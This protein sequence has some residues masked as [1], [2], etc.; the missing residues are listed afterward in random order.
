MS[1]KEAGGKLFHKPAQIGQSMVETA[2]IA[3]ILILMLIGVFEVGWALRGY[4]IILN[5]TREA[6]RFAARGYVDFSDGSGYEV[7]LDHTLDTLG[8]NLANP[9]AL[10]EGDANVGMILTPTANANGSII[11][12][13]FLINTQQPLTPLSVITS[14]DP[15]AACSIFLAEPPDPGY[16]EDDTI[17]GPH[18]HP[19]TQTY[20]FPNPPVHPSRINA[21]ELA[22]Q[23]RAENNYFNCIL[24]S[25]DPSALWSTNS[26][27][28]VEIFF[29]QPQLLGVPVISN[30]FTDPVP[31]YAFTQ[32]RVTGDVRGLGR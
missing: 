20:S 9:N 10:E 8:Y 1:L 7:V 5:A 14:T 32:M 3:P 29:D 30:R 4:M 6:A 25:K 31:L 2:L 23:L 19:L 16:T 22:D 18:T 24:Y 15:M 27:V 13:H 11:I 17:Q 26:V 21:V 12:S 28:V